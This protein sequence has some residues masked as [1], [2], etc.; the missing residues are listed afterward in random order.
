[1][2]ILYIK[3]IK[4]LH[5]SYIRTYKIVSVIMIIGCN[6]AIFLLNAASP[7]TMVYLI[8]L[9]Q[10]RKDIRRKYAL[11]CKCRSIRIQDCICQSLL[12]IVGCFRLWWRLSVLS[13]RREMHQHLILRQLPRCTLLCK[14]QFITYNTCTIYSYMTCGKSVFCCL[15][16]HL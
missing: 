12:F 9:M 2:P 11:S 5:G 14:N 13:W 6:V 7:K 10:E 3:I 4:Y 16:L 15:L 1:M 8:M